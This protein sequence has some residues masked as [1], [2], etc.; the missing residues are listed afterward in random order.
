MRISKSIIKNLVLPNRKPL[1][2]ML[3]VDLL[4]F[5]DHPL[6]ERVGPDT[7]ANA[8]T[9]KRLIAEALNIHEDNPEVQTWINL[10]SQ[11]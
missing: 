8:P 11:N 9:L 6:D 10:N 5:I 1:I 4:D 2:D 7:S 3:N